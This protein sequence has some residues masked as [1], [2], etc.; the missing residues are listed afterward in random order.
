MT[1]LLRSLARLAFRKG[2]VGGSREWA[3]LWV[4]TALWSRARRK[5]DE[6]PPVIHR[7]V[8]EPGESIRISLY[9]PRSLR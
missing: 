9:D 8:L 2:V 1:K 7:E 6:P 3:V 4:L 5:S